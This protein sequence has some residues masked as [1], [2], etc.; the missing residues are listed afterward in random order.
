M[1]LGL[2]VRVFLCIL[3][4]G[5]FLYAYIHKQNQ[6]TEL[7]LQIP[8]VAIELKAVAQEN[9]RL[10]FEVDQFENPVRLMEL[11]REPQFSHL[12]HPLVNEIITVEVD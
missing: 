2:F 7:R 1:N 4:L 8:A 12:K 11:A 5:A 10:Q 6:I 3:C 9:T